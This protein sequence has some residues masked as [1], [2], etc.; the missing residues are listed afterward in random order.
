MSIFSNHQRRRRRMYQHAPQQ[1]VNLEI[2][3]IADDIVR[4]NFNV[5]ISADDYEDGVTIKVNGDSV[6]F[7][8]E[9]QTD[10]TEIRYT[11][12]DPVVFGDEV[13]W[14][15]DS[16]PGSYIDEIDDTTPALESFGEQTVVNNVPQ[17]L[18]GDALRADAKA[19]Y[20]KDETGG[21]RADSTGRGNNLSVY[22]VEVP[23]VS[24]V[25]GNAA[26]IDHQGIE[27]LKALI[28]SRNSDLG[29]YGNSYYYL[30]SWVKILDL[31]SFNIILLFSTNGI[32]EATLGFGG[33]TLDW[34]VGDNGFVSSDVIAEDTWVLV[35]AYYDQSNNQIGIAINNS[36]YITD[37]PVNLSQATDSP[38]FSVG[39]MFDG[40]TPSEVISHFDMDETLIMHR[41]PTS[42][43]RAYL[44]N[45]GAGRSLFP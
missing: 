39:I 28:H 45:A 34:S 5:S 41:L 10:H 43:E 44:Y 21:T 26:R 9:R 6:A 24:G 22:D 31:S 25:I 16:G 35:E 15:Y 30:S 36:S 3:I 20:K 13:T 19:Y 1:H 18:I 14:A 38:Y 27:D 7:T 40:E 33:T 32:F 2:G 8:A 29:V 17:D 37:S 4:A 23:S 42:N 12:A 11:L